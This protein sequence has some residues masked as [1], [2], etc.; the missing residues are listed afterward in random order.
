MRI[1]KIVNIVFN[2]NT[3]IIR[4]DYSKDLW[5]VDCGDT[6]RILEILDY[7]ER[8]VGV[9]ITHGHSDHIYGLNELISIFPYVHIFTTSFG[10]EEFN[11]DK[12]NFSRYHEEYPSFTITKQ[13]N[14]KE[15]GDGSEIDVLGRV[16]KVYATP[17]HDPS[18]ACFEMDGY[19]FTGDSYIPDASV[20]TKFPNSDK[21]QAEESKKR[22][23][24]LAEGKII[25]P[26]HTLIETNH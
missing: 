23:I 14:I 1:D 25:M 16:C 4:A 10:I 20:V 2:S 15:I 22:I 19:L 6:K 13:D 17:G 18:C 21:H 7:D 8:I 24:A 26:G 12:L 11:S 9:L 3:Y 5:L